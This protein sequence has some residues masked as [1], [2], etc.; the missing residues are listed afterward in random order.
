MVADDLH[1][2]LQHI[3][4]EEQGFCQARN[5]RQ[6]YVFHFGKE[7]IRAF[8]GPILVQVTDPITRFCVQLNDILAFVPKVFNNAP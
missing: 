3:L 8:P 4:C 5:T 1:D 7:F 2:L 6:Q